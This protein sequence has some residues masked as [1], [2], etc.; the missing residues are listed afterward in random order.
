MLEWPGG[1]GDLHKAI[2]RQRQMWIGDRSSSHAGATLA[3]PGTLLQRVSGNPMASPELL[4]VS[5]GAMLG[6]LILT[7]TV[8]RLL[9]TSDAGDE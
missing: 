2:R 3:L 6:V 1:Q 5:G 7:W 9:Y 8:R 4:G